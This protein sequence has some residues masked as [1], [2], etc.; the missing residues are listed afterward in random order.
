MKQFI[1]KSS[2]GFS[3]MELLIAIVI[4]A[5]LLAVAIPSYLIYVTKSRRQDAIQTLLSIQ[6]Q[7]EKWRLNNSTYGSLG[8]VW[9]GVATTE[10]GY[11]AIAITG[12]SATGYTITATT[13][14][15]QVGDSEG[16]TDCDTLT[17]TNNNGA[18]TKTPAAC[19][20]EG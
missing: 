9:G 4:A 17:L 7:E 18:V 10:G 11:Y 6:L 8:D 1:N 20:G 5:I 19:W 16:G 15:S 3:L 14:G 12:V 2:Q 13:T